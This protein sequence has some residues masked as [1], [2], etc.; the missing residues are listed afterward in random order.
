MTEQEKALTK[1][2][3]YR[4]RL[5][6]I[7]YEDIKT[8]SRESIRFIPITTAKLYKGESIDRERLNGETDFFKSQEEILHINDQHVIDNYLTEF[9][10]IEQNK[11][12]FSKM[13]DDK[14]FGAI[15]RNYMIKKV[16]TRF[17][18]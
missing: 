15:V 13:M 14:N 16:Y 5:E 11:D 3:S 8:L 6:E 17:N 9:V 18:S 2:I 7:E 1:L 4:D 10:R 12:I